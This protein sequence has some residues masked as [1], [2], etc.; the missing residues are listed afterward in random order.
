[1]SARLIG[2]ELIVDTLFIIVFAVN[3]FDVSGSL[4]SSQQEGICQPWAQFVALPDAQLTPQNPGIA[5]SGAPSG[6]GI[7]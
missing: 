1:M 3:M 5:P 4:Q 6:L 7:D 2:R